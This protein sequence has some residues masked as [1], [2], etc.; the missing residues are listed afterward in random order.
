[1][2][3]VFWIIFNSDNN[4]FITLFLSEK[5]VLL[6]TEFIILSNDPKIIKDLYYKPNI[7]D[8]LQFSYKKTIHT[9][10][11]S[12]LINN[13]NNILLN[14]CFLIKEITNMFFIKNRK[15]LEECINIIYKKSYNLSDKFFILFHELNKFE[16]NSKNFIKNLKN[17][18]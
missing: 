10:N 11:I 17:I 9:I 16:N 3:N 15:E 13:D 5:S 4:I 8:A 12:A 6:F 14:K 7:I 18:L 2:F 1:M